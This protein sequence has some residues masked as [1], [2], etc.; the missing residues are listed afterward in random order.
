MLC[1]RNTISIKPQPPLHIPELDGRDYQVVVYR[2]KAIMPSGDLMIFIDKN[3]GEVL[4]VI[5]GG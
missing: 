5:E 4:C 3:S 2:R 1:V